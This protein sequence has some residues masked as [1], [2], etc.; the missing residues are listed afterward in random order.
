M[1]TIECERKRRQDL[2][3]VP[4][5]TIGVQ[6]NQR[7]QQNRQMLLCEMQEMAA[8]G[9]IEAPLCRPHAAEA[10]AEKAE[11][12]MPGVYGDVQLQSKFGQTFAQAFERLNVNV[13]GHHPNLCKIQRR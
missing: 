10:A 11:S 7:N 2:Q 12:R 8:T 4:D 9:L 6:Q 3:S 13:S 5:A 1:R